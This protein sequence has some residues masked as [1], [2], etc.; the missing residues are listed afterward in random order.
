VSPSKRWREADTGEY[1][2]LPARV[3]IASKAAGD[4]IDRWLR[5]DCE[6]DDNEL[7]REMVQDIARGWLNPEMEA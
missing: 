6:A 2:R 3:L 5:N 1:T 7:A 4:A